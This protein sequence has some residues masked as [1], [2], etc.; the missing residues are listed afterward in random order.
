MLTIDFNTIIRERHSVKEFDPNVKISHEEMLKILEEATLAPSSV[1]L[2]PWRFVVVD[3]EKQKEKL[4]NLV[5]FNQRQLNTSAAMI[6]ILGDM[7]H[8]DYA[9]EIFSLAV[10]RNTMPQEV[11]DNYM[12]TLPKAFSSMSPQKI[13]ET[14]LIDGGLVAMQLMLV[15]KAHG[16]D[17]NPIGGF[18][19][20]E[21]LEAL[22]V[23][24]ERYVPVMIVAIGKAAKPAHASVRLPIERVTTFNHVDKEVGQPKKG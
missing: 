9:D 1:N 5:R 14:A 23:D 11:K 4:Q 19:R 2:Q 21:L 18:E 6:L 15:A 12:T 10:E 22:G 24:T 7:N 20:K 13:R 17:T 3:D 8:F 16:Y